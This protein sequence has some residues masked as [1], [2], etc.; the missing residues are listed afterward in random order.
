MEEELVRSPES[1]HWNES[2]VKFRFGGKPLR[3]QGQKE[4]A[5]EMVDSSGPRTLSMMSCTEKYHLVWTSFPSLGQ[6]VC[7]PKRWALGGSSINR[8]VVVIVS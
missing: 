2:N 1:K 4:T 7:V 6:A 5:Q 8:T 3:V